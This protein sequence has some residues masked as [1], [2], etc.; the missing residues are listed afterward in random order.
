[1]MDLLTVFKIFNYHLHIY[2][3][4]KQCSQIVIIIG[5]LRLVQCVDC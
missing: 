1:M 5:S 3:S 4:D 2:S